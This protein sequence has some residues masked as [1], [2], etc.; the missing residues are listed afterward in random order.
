MITLHTRY[1][2]YKPALTVDEE[3]RD[4][5]PDPLSVDFS[6]GKLTKVPTPHRVTSADLDKFWFYFYSKYH[7]VDLDDL[8]LHINGIPY[9]GMLEPGSVL[10]EVVPEDLTGWLLLQPRSD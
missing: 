8:L 10:Y 6:A 9:A 1:D 4:Q 7:R 3:T 2:H 5:Y